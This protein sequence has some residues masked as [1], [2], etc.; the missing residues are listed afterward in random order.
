MSDLLDV[1]EELFPHHQVVLEVDNSSGHTKGAIDALK[2]DQMNKDWGGKKPCMRPSTIV[3][4]CLGEK[5]NRG[6]KLG[7]VQSMVFTAEDAAQ[8][9]RDSKSAGPFYDTGAKPYDRFGSKES[10]GQLT[11]DEWTKAKVKLKKKEEEIQAEIDKWLKLNNR[12][13]AD[14]VPA[15]NEAIITDLFTVPGW[16]GKPKG[17]RQILWERGLWKNNMVKSKSE[18]EKQSL[19]AQEKERLIPSPERSFDLV[20]LNCPDFRETKS[21][22]A[23]FVEASGHILLLGVKGHCEMA[24]GGIEYC[25]GIAKK[26][27]RKNNDCV[28]KNLLTNVETALQVTLPL[29]R[30][31]RFE[32]RCRAYMQVYML[33]GSSAGSNLTHKEIE[34]QLKEYKT[35]RN[36]LEIENEYLNAELAGDEI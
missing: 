21:A 2:V 22:L 23:E 28:T 25:W 17:I 1:C 3:A 18:K 6:L 29:E 12:E 34:N 30:I 32:R 24:G 11:E 19:K 13:K 36:I 7:D 20:L 26:Y 8:W 9:E 15:L 31:W 5:P 14:T 4:G 10:R 35:H 27:F 16:Q 33:N